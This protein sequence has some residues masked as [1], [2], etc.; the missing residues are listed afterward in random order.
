MRVLKRNTFL[1]TTAIT[2][3]CLAGGVFLSLPST[4]TAQN[5]PIANQI[6][7]QVPLQTLSPLDPVTNN[8]NNSVPLQPL[9]PL[10]Q[11]QLENSVKSL[12]ETGSKTDTGQTVNP[13]YEVQFTTAAYYVYMALVSVGGWINWIGGWL[14]DA[15]L[16]WFVMDMA[17]TTKSFGLVETI[18]TVWA[19][20]RDLFNLLF[21]FGLILV[22]FKLILGIDDSGSK[23]TLGTIVIAALLINFSLYAAQVVVDLGNIL[24]VEMAQQ[25]RTPSTYKMMGRDVARISDSFISLAKLDQISSSTLPFAANIQEGKV[26]DAGNNSLPIPQSKIDI[27]GALV[28]GLS[29]AAMLIVVGFVFVAGAFLM[30]LRYFYLLFLM[31]FSPI[32]VLGWVLPQFKSQSSK[33]WST[34][35]KQAIIG[36]AYLMMI[37]IALLALKSFSSLQS[38]SITTFIMMSLIVAGFSWASL[39]VAKHIGAM[40]AAGAMSLGQSWGR[41]A[42]VFAGNATSGTLARGLRGTVGRKMYDYAESDAAKDKAANSWWGRRQLNLAKRLGDSSFDARQVAGAGKKLG[43]GEGRKGGYKTVTDEIA[44]REKEY[45]DGLGTVDDD[46]KRV[47]ELQLEVDATEQAMEAKKKDIRDRQDEITKLEEQKKGLTGKAKNDKQA[48]IDIKKAQINASRGDIEKYKEDIDKQ[49]EAVQ[50]EKYRR[51]IGTLP[52]TIAEQL[53]TKRDFVKSKLAEY[54]TAPETDKAAK[55]EEIAK[56][57]KEL[58]E[59]EKEANKQAGGYATSVENAGSIKNL[60]TGR[61]ASQNENAGKEIRNEYKKKVKSKDK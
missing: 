6:N 53:K 42:R 2:V 18:N 38:T 27:G 15:S 59:A 32:M 28:V 48:E 23:R 39:I 25:I 16:S 50:R 5:D 24:S 4:A 14:L 52:K 51:Q 17:E 61:N 58:A 49:K 12:T 43:I 41:S 30:F 55:R 1:V 26:S 40:G 7:N 22:G 11:E 46:D 37:Y 20:I 45:A 60:F 8:I 10:T 19:L 36:P 44:K 31:M 33:W 57:K 21:I 3:I 9:Q 13:A 54:K 56:L 29:V 35:I 47:S 34:L